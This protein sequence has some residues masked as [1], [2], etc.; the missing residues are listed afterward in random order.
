MLS[1]RLIV[2][3]FAG[4]ISQFMTTVQGMPKDVEAQRESTWGRNGQ[5]KGYGGGQGALREIVKYIYFLP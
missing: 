3:M 4:R 2:Q 5:I 1:Y